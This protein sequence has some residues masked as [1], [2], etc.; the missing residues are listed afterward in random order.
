MAQAYGIASATV[1]DPTGVRAAI[2]AMWS[3][4]HRPYLLQVMIST[5]ANAYPKLAFG[6][7][8]TEME[9]FAT[10]VGIEST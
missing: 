2:D 3:E 4:P 6:R 8:I 9:P 10:P 7:P 1:A 5:F